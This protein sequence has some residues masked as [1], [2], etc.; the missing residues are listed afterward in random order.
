MCGSGTTLVEASISGYQ[1]VGLD[2]NPVAVLAASAKTSPLDALDLGE[3]EAFCQRLDLGAR[4]LPVGLPPLFVNRDKWFL[5]HVQEELAASLAGAMELTRVRARVLVLASLSAIVV[6]VSN[7]E[8]ETRWCAKPQSIAPGET[9]TRLARKIRKSAVAATDFAR[10]ARAEAIVV[11][12]DSRQLPLREESIGLIVTSPP[13]ANSHDYYLYNTLRMFWLGYP[14]DQVQEAEI[15]SRNR[16]SDRRADVN[17]YLDA[18]SVIMCESQRVLVPGGH[19]VFVVADSVIRG[20]FFDMGKEYRS[21]ASNAGLTTAGEFAFAHKKFNSSFQ[22]GF[23]TDR[24][25][26]THVLVFKKQESTR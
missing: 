21:L 12:T 19:A 10:H 15:G 20:E 24:H 2:L 5:P 23:G 17:H 14:V 6:P 18:M 3:V 1:S 16:H 4:S 7:Q 26:L 8:S 25:K 11:R 13:Y 9:F 22:T